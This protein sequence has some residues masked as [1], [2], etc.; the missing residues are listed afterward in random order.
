MVRKVK[1]TRH[2]LTACPGC[3]AHIRVAENLA[4]TVCPFCATALKDAIRST[5]GSALSRVVKASRS[6]LVA[7]S[8]LGIGGMSACTNSE[9]VPGPPADTIVPDAAHD[10]MPQ[11]EYGMPADITI[12]SDTQKDAGPQPAYGIPADT[13]SPD[14]APDAGPQP[15]YGIPGDA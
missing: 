7:A 13:L 11:P 10:A 12:P 6:G 8:I 5:G 9:P 15:E 14:T 4:D 2:G 1:I 3:H